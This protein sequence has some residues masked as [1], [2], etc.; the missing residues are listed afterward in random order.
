MEVEGGGGQ[1]RDNCA[2]GATTSIDCKLMSNEERL[3]ASPRT[4]RLAA[5]G[6]AQTLILSSFAIRIVNFNL[7][8]LPGRNI[9]NSAL[10]VHI[11]KVNSTDIDIWA[12]YPQ[13]PSGIR[14]RQAARFVGDSRL[15]LGGDRARA[16]RGARRQ[17]EPLAFAEPNSP[18][19][20]FMHLQAS[21]SPCS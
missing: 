5:T 17:I 7:R 4:C 16:V 10:L 9:F 13:M 1:W 18:T 14:G 3:S 8:N 21:C 20:W 12:F 2:L 15:G 11:A 6:A 19:N